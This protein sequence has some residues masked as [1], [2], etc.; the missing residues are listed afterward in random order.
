[1]SITNQLSNL[2]ILSITCYF[3]VIFVGVFFFD[4]CLGCFFIVYVSII[5]VCCL[6]MVHCAYEEIFFKVEGGLN[7]NLE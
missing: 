2:S 7:Y 5:W 6:S 1:M 3:F 4:L